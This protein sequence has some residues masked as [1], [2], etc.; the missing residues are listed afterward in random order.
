MTAPQ[1][2]MNSTV[3]INERLIVALDIDSVEKAR[4][5][6]DQLD[7]LGVA[8]KIGMQMFTHGGPKF[9]EELVDR[10][11]RIFLDL[12]F[13]DIPNTVA[14]AGIEA[15]RLGVWM[16]NVHAGGGSEMMKRTAAEVSE[17]CE[18]SSRNRPLIIGVTVLT[19]SSVIT[20]REQGIQSSVEDRV[21]LLAK[22]TSASGL[23]GVVASANEIGFIRNEIK[24]SDFLIVTPG[25]RPENATKDD[26]T[27]VMSPGAA[28]SKGADHIVVGRPII[29]AADRRQA[30]ERILNEIREV[31]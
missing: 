18:A 22:L 28:I 11:S 21:T 26:Q 14:K 19:S 31:Q 3:S 2:E 16:F 20:L 1:T 25:I 6:V 12:K 27:R 17:F 15:A 10:G 30:A 29:A 13:H 24:N 9:V 8:F 23:D 5:V 4:S 7:G